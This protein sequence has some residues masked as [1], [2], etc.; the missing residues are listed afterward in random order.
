MEAFFF[1]DFYQN[2]VIPNLANAF[3]G[4][5]IFVFSAE[6]TAEFARARYYKSSQPAGLTVK[7]HIRRTA[8]AAAGTGVDDLFLLQ[9]T[10]THFKTCI[11]LLFMQKSEEICRYIY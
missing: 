9:F 3:P 10:K 4:D 5:D 11:F 7:F 8:Q 1:L 2:D 6:K